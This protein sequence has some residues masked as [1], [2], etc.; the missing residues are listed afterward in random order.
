VDG[1]SQWG[2]SVAGLFR[3]DVKRISEVLAGAH[4]PSQKWQLLAYIEQDPV[5]CARTDPR[6]VQQLWALPVGEYR[7]LEQV[8]VGAAR[9]ARGHPLRADI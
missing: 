2:K 1:T 9:T 5:L 4:W 6:T 7:N 3:E 8:L